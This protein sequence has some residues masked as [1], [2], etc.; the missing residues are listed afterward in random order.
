MGWSAVAAALRRGRA[1]QQS[2]SA[3]SAP[4]TASS[5][6]LGTEA[7]CGG[8]PLADSREASSASAR[9]SALASSAVRGAPPLA[10][11]CMASSTSPSACAATA[12]TGDASTSASSAALA[13][14]AVRGISPL[15][16]SC[17]ASISNI[18]K[19]ICFGMHQRQFVAIRHLRPHAWHHLRVLRPLLRQPGW[20][21]ASSSVLPTAAFFGDPSLAVGSAKVLLLMCDFGQCVHSGSSIDQYEATTQT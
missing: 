19:I 11:S 10:V 12:V 9:S 16:V 5:S 17:E 21:S 2:P 18:G 1:V 14:A 20:A 6:A 15:A 4:S 7:G 13:S 3:I 8:P